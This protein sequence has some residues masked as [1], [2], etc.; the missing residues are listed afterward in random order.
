MNLPLNIKDILDY[1]KFYEITY[2]LPN[3]LQFLHSSSINK[4]YVERKIAENY[5]SSFFLDNSFNLILISFVLPWILIVLLYIIQR[6]C[7]D[8]INKRIRIKYILNSF[9]MFTK[10]NMVFLLYNNNVQEL[11][12]FSAL[13]LKVFSFSDIYTIFSNISCLVF[14]IGNIIMIIWI[15]KII[16]NINNNPY[17]PIPTEYQSI[18]TNLNLENKYSIYFP[19]L[20]ILRKFIL[21]F[22]IVFLYDNLFVLLICLMILTIIMYLIIRIVEP[23][24]KKYRNIISEITELLQCCLYSLIFLYNQNKLGSLDEGGLYIGYIAVFI[25]AIIIALNFGMLMFN[26]IMT[27]LEILCKFNKIRTQIQLGEKISRTIDN[28][29]IKDFTYEKIVKDIKSGIWYKSS[30]SNQKL[31]RHR[32]NSTQYENPLF[33]KK[34][35]EKIKLKYKNLNEDNKSNEYIDKSSNE[36]NYNKLNLEMSQLNKSCEEVEDIEESKRKINPLLVIA[37]YN[38]D[39]ANHKEDFR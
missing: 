30:L 11:S 19:L 16:K 35:K 23:F 4:T 33:S 29:R 10:Y 6:Y 2:L 21:S 12:L 28:L 32:D 26:M 15:K 7:S 24:E 14:M 38:E 17:S 27:L 36:I 22:L 18:F 3:D 39:F 1:L 25:L 20:I 13:E 31:I 9:W 34:N 5:D 37:G 8:W